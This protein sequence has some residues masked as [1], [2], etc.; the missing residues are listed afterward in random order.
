MTKYWKILTVSETLVRSIAKFRVENNTVVW[1][2]EGETE[3]WPNLF[4]SRIRARSFNL[5]AKSN[6]I[7]QK[8]REAEQL[9]EPDTH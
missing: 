4:C 2:R 9:T 6:M 7:L 5:R 1:S 3:T 8:I